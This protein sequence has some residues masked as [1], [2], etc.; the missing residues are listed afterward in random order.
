MAE[1]LIMAGEI[2]TTNKRKPWGKQIS[3][4]YF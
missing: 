4:F 3:V 1:N 2:G